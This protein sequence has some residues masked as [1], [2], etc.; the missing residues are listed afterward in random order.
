M[1][2]SSVELTPVQIS[3]KPRSRT[4]T[5]GRYA[6][7]V[8]YAIPAI[9]SAA[10]IAAFMFVAVMRLF[11]PYEIEWLESG[12]LEHVQRFANG[13]SLYT[14]PSVE[15]TQLPYAPF[16]FVVGAGISLLTG[17]HFWVLR[18][19]SLAA[20]LATFWLIY[21]LVKKETSNNLAGF[22]AAGVYAATF[23]IS[24]WW[25]DV[26]K[27]DSLFMAVTLA[28]VWAAR[29]ASSRNTAIFAAGLMALAVM[30]KQSA[31]FVLAPIT[32]YLLATRWRVGLS[33]LLGSVVLLGGAI[34]M[35]NSATQGWYWFYNWE[36]LL[37]HDV[38]EENRVRFF[39]RDLEPFI[40]AAFL[41][42]LAARHFVSREHRWMAGFWAVT[43]LGMVASSYSARLHSGGAENVLMP[44]FA[45]AA[46]AVGLS[47]ALLLQNPQRTKL[48]AVAGVVGV[49]Q[50]ANLAY[51]PLP[52][53]PSNDDRVAVDRFVT[54]LSNVPGDVWVVSHPG[55]ALLADKE[56][57]AG[58]G[59]IEDV[60]RGDDV[61]AKRALESSIADAIH[62]QR[63]RA[64][65]LDG[66]GDTR[67]FPADWKNYYEQMPGWVM[68]SNNGHPIVNNTGI[69][70]EVWVPVGDS[71]PMPAR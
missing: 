44:A 2:V 24:G 6:A 11:Y 12:I 53:V 27:P 69:P 28:A 15:F 13:Q 40:P 39:T 67:G 17:A 48:A 56:T 71:L 7:R 38:L 57:F 51:N 52:Q 70:R 61:V 63:F 46:I 10:A 29:R 16:T 4:A 9:A 37:Q 23:Q 8:A 68:P 14:P 49:L 20:T 54:W 42:L 65:I 1:S 33:Y 21:A 35:I 45:A 26:G 22:I 64:I 31:V 5:K 55:Y 50:F 36:L 59:G 19:L 34:A 60:M 30:T 66:P 25:F 32:L 41:I 47:L 62:T 18:A 58:K 43:I 3:F